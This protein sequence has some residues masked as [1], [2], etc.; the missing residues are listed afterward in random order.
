M[1]NKLEKITLNAGELCEPGSPLEGL[2]QKDGIENQN[3]PG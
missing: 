1:Q 2:T 3:I